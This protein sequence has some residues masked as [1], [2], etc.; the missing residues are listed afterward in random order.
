MPTA[1]DCPEF[2]CD[3]V[4]GLGLQVAGMGI[5]RRSGAP[6]ASRAFIER[7]RWQWRSPRGLIPE[8]HQDVVNRTGGAVEQSVSGR[9]AR[10]CPGLGARLY[11]GGRPGPSGNR[12]SP[13]PTAVLNQKG[14]EETDERHPPLRRAANTRYVSGKASSVGDEKV[15]VWVCFPLGLLPR[16]NV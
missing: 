9:P 12:E 2:P 10:R 15:D 5:E 14:T 7:R 16:R 1:R 4:H 8:R 13:R 3:V 6:R 11:L